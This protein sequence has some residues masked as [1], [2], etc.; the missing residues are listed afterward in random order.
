MLTSFTEAEMRPIAAGFRD[1]MR[2]LGWIDG[3]NL[4][5]DL[6]AAGGD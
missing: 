3:R 2:E 5:I 1:R 4:T 6:R